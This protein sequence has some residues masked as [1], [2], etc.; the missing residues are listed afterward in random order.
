MTLDLLQTNRFTEAGLLIQIEQI[1]L[2]VRVIDNP[3]EIAF[4]MA[5]V[6]GVEPNKRAKQAPVRFDDSIAK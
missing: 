4:E 3:P 5:V 6:N 2:Q 1:A